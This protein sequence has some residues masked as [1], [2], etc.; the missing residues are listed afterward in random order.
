MSGLRSNTAGCEINQL[1]NIED[2]MLNN[3]LTV[4][5]RKILFWA[6]RTEAKSV[7]KHW[8]VF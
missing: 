7:A 1:E 4:S 3:K 2:A 5:T 6:K 8:Q